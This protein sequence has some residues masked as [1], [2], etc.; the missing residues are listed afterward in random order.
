MGAG[1]SLNLLQ[2][3]WPVTGGVILEQLGGAS[4]WFANG[5]TSGTF[6][7]PAEDF[8]TLSQNTGTGV[9]TR[10][11][12]DG[13]KLTFD[14]TGKQTAIT[15]RNNNSLAEG[16]DGSSRLSTLTDFNSL[17]TTLAYNAQSQVQTITDPAIDGKTLRGS[18]DRA[19]NLPAL[20]LVTAQLWP[21]SR[22]PV[23]SMVNCLAHGLRFL[24]IPQ[25]HDRKCTSSRSEGYYAA[26]SP[27]LGIPTFSASPTW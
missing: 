11:L 21:P 9:Y 26:A 10:T 22:M 4:L 1:W 19:N 23:C 24:A 16:Y 17:V 12:T 13:T 27:P 2:R 14:S 20:H 15:D 8:S 18:H 25:G 5:G 7:T 6:V 3:L